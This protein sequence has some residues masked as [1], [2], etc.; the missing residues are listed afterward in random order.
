MLIKMQVVDT[1]KAGASSCCWDRKRLSPARLEATSASGGRG[2]SAA[3]AL[4]RRTFEPETSFGLSP[5]GSCRPTVSASSRSFATESGG[6]LRVE[7]AFYQ[8]KYWTYLYSRQAANPRSHCPNP[9]SRSS[10]RLTPWS[11][12]RP[13]ATGM[14][15]T[16]SS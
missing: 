2:V 6:I 7:L 13:S 14:V 5:R 16:T 12:W 10:H 3:A 11:T 4:P 1:L 15:R 9:S 8:F